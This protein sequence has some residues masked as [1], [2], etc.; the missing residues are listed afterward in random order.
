MITNQYRE[1]EEEYVSRRNVY[2]SPPSY[3]GRRQYTPNL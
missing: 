1:K 3:E 2:Y